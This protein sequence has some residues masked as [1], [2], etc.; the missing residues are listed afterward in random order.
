MSRLNLLLVPAMCYITACLLPAVWSV[1]R[2]DVNK[3]QAIPGIVCLLGIPLVVQ[4][5]YW[6]ANVGFFAGCTAI[7]HRRWRAAS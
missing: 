4:Y 5:P 6:W 1:N 2:Y 7:V 3:P